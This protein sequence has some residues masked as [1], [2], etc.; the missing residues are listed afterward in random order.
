MQF[1]DQ[2]TAQ[3]RG[4]ISTNN[5][6]IYFGVDSTNVASG[7]GRQSVRLVSKKS[8]NHALVI[9]DLAHMPAGCGTWPAFWTVGPNWPNAGELDIIEGANSQATNSMALHTGPG[10]S[11][12]QNGNFSGYIQTP[13]CDVNAPGQPYNAGCA[14]RSSN[15]GSYGS[16]FNQGQGGVYATEWSSDHISIWFFP[17]GA[18]PADMSSA[19]PDPSNWGQPV[20]SYGSGSCDID[21][22]F[23]NNLLVFDTTFCGYWAGKVWSSDPVCGSKASTCQAFVQNNPSA[24]KEAY[25]SVNSLKVFQSNGQGSPSRSVRRRSPLSSRAQVDA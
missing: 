9:L 21:Q 6:A 17:R 22:F 25:W 4:L 19:S 8:Y 16:G 11:A 1:V 15:P 2:N 3:S 5:N 12:V 23:N 10:C 24:F 14:I 7:S 18:I 20:A 13:N